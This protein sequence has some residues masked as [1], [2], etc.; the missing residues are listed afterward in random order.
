MFKNKNKCEAKPENC[1]AT[2]ENSG[3]TF[4]VSKPNIVKYIREMYIILVVLNG[5]SW[6]LRTERLMNL[7][8]LKEYNKLG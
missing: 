7:L 8:P 5:T 1:I 2:R 4:N 6:M 3:P